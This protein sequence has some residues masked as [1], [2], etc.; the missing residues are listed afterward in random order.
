[1]QNDSPNTTLPHEM[2]HYFDLFHTWFRY[3]KD[4]NNYDKENIARTGPCTNWDKTGDLLKD[5]PA[6]PYSDKAGINNINSNCQFVY[7]S[8]YVDN[9]DQTNYSP[10]T[11]NMMI[12][13]QKDNCRTT[14]TEDQMERM[15]ETLMDYR[16]DLLYN[17]VYLENSINSSNAGGTLHFGS[18]N[19]NSGSFVLTQDGN[20]NIGTNNERFSNY[21]S[22]GL[23]Y[24]HNQWNS[25]ND[26]YF[27]IRSVSITN[28][29]NQFANFDP[30]KYAKIQ[31]GLEGVPFSGQGTLEFQDPWY[32][33]SDGT[34]PGNYWIQSTSPL[35]PTGKAG[36]TEKG[37]FLNQQ[38]VSGQPYYSA[39][40]QA[41]QTINSYPAN[42]QFWRA[43]SDKAELN[44]ANSLTTSV[45]FK[46][47]NAVVTANYKGNL[48]SGDNYGFNSNSQRK[49][50]RTDNG[51]LHM[52]YESMNQVWYT[53][54]TDGGT[55]WLQEQ[56]VDDISNNTK[57]CS[58]SQ[59]SNIV[60]IV[61]QSDAIPSIRVARFNNGVRSWIAD[62]YTL[63][64]YGYNAQAVIAA[65]SSEG[66]LVVF[67]PTSTSLLRARNV[68][69]SGLL[70]SSWTIGTDFQID[71]S[72]TSSTNA[73]L[74]YLNQFNFLAFQNGTSEIRYVK[75]TAG[76]DSY[77]PQE[78]SIVSSVSGF[79]NNQSPS[80]SVQAENPVISWNGFNTS[81]PSAVVR[82]KVGSTWSGFNSFGNSTVRYTNNNSR[83]DGGE[84][85]IIAWCNIYNEHKFVKL[86]NGLY[87][88]IMT[89]PESGGNGQ[90]QISNGIDFSYIKSVV[91]KSPISSIYTVK[92]VNYNFQ[93][94]QKVNNEQSINYGRTVVVQQDKKNFVYY[95]GGVKVD[96]ENIKFKDF[97]D[98][99][100]IENSEKMDEIMSTEYFHLT[101]KSELEFSNLYYAFDNEEYKQWKE[102]NAQFKIEL[103]NLNG[104]TTKGEF[105]I[106]KFE[107]STITD[108]ELFYKIDCSN[109]EEGTY[110]LRVNC[111]VDGDAKYFVNNVMYEDIPNLSKKTFEEIKIK[112]NGTPNDYHLGNNYPNPFNPTTVISFNLPQQ[113]HVTLKVY[114]V[115]GKEV[116]TLVEGVQN[117]GRHEVK[118]DAS[119]LA[120]GIYFYTLKAG[121]FS[122]TN[123]MILVK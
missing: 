44:N 7:H 104:K 12:T 4:D 62:V 73:S 11:D 65:Y 19:Y 29:N 49:V 90:I 117:S 81:V 38:I 98:T 77:S 10:L 86:E 83:R 33:K 50:V 66:A 85:S 55:T 24:K 114:D 84:G 35:E 67:K 59:N 69:C 88:S 99:M 56:K 79:T 16:Y 46:D 26:D 107:E 116:A 34:Q 48:I 87:S 82:R 2:G 28:D 54:S 1:M 95:L 8:S 93:T 89:L 39:R 92:P 68:R 61:Y 63:S 106:S 14:F 71:Y 6:D 36:A 23:N 112:S 41:T 74:V 31:I 123:K 76:I 111:K 70:C 91:F 121:K 96:G 5:T 118:F 53:R 18:Q 58:I 103:V 20:Y 110:Y 13:Q 97:V 94:L 75:F 57:S 52:V 64:S 22:S 32:V 115:L 100:K 45:V 43:A 51:Q 15:N 119:E 25:A 72:T 3:F 9:C 122:Q 30:L 60:F 120:S 101:P 102:N 113:E 78:T 21:Q 27:L 108:D 105:N 109:L 42:F 40:T 17:A 80:I 47:I 37:V